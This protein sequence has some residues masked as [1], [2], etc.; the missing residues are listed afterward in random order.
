MSFSFLSSDAKSGVAEVAP[1]A[2][3]GRE[4]LHDGD[5]LLT[6]PI[7]RQHFEI[8]RFFRLRGR[9]RERDPHDE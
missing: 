6:R 9:L 3:R 4:V 8:F 7:L 1:H 2:E 5:D